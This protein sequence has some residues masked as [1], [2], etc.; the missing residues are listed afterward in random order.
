M[1][2]FG[3]PITQLIVPAGK[4]LLPFQEDVVW[5]SLEFLTSNES[6]GIYNACEQGLGKTIITLC[7]LS[8]LSCGKVLIICPKVMKFT[9]RSFITEW[10]HLTQSDVNIINSP[11]DVIKCPNYSVSI[12]NYGQVINSKVLGQLKNIKW[13]ALVCDEAHYLK[14]Y[15]AQRTVAVMEVLWKHC[16]YKLLLSGTPFIRDIADGYVP[17]SK[18]APSC[19]PSY[20]SFCEEYAYRQN[21]DWGVKYF[22]VKNAEKLSSI[23]RSSFYIRKT[24]KEVLPD[25]PPKQF[26]RVELG[27]EY[28]VKLPKD[29]AEV[30]EQ[31]AKILALA[32]AQGNDNPA[33]PKCLMGYK[34]LQGEIKAPFVS[35]FTSELLDLETP[36]VV[37][38]YHTNVITTLVTQLKK[39]DPRVITGQTPDK[40]RYEYVNDFQ[41]AKTN[42]MIMNIVAGGVGITL[43]RSSTV[44]FAELTFSPS[45]I[46]QAI[47][48][49][50]RINTKNAVTG[51]YF[52]A[53]GSLDQEIID[54][55]MEKARSFAQVVE[56]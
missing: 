55:V 8:S 2:D 53:K 11:K 26:A 36:T 35:E 47:C 54:V 6:K 31:Q 41:E 19:F 5:R 12:L 43:D 14:N 45:E 52:V 1:A 29:E 42:L 56:N 24:K 16:T 49:C 3:E 27:P 22:G 28:C 46:D 50:H 15:K 37:F 40:L 17:F 7:T 10:T 9:W 44:V 13:D 38:A 30:A 21:H 48:R 34:K 32:V 39:Y 25:L 18:L 4:K 23:I 51:Y 20:I 33:I